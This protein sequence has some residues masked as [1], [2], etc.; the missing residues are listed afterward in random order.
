MKK[1]KAHVHMVK[2]K[3]TSR[4]NPQQ[5][6]FELKQR[7][8]LALNKLADRDTY[9]LGVEDLEKTVEC[10]TP[11]GVA[12]FLSCILDTDSE[13][14]SAVRKECIRL[15]GVLATFHEDL[16][17]SHIGKMV[18]GIVKRLKDSD[19][20]VRDACV[21]AFGV[22][23]SKLSSSRIDTDG[24][25]VV[26]VRPL[27]EALG[28]QNKQVQFGSA[29]SLSRVIDNIYD[30]PPL[31]LQK[32]L[33]KTVK[34]LKNPHFMAKP[35]IIE[36]NR[37]IILAGG[38]PT[39]SSLTAAMTS[40][41]ESL[42]NNDWATRKAACAALGDI[43]TCGAACL[44]SYRTSCIRCLESCRFDKVKPVRDIALQALQLW[45]NLPGANTPEP[46]EAGSSVKEK[47]YKDEYG[48]ITS[49]SI[50]SASGST[51]TDKTPLK[52]GN[53][54]PK[55]RV[56]LSSRNFGSAYT[57]KCQQSE[58]NDWQIEIAVPKRHNI[59]AL[60]NQHG[61][62]EG[63]SVIT[64]LGSS[65]NR[66][67]ER[68]NSDIR[69]VNSIGYASVEVDDKQ[70]CSSASN[71]FTES[72]KPKVVTTHFD[73]FDDASL[74]KSTG[75]SQRFAADEVIIEEQKYLSKVH[76]RVSLDSTLTNSTSQTV[77]ECCSQT[78]KE[79]V[80]IRKHLLE[81]EDKQSS[82]MNMLKVFTTSVMDSVSAVQMKVSN[83]ELVVDKMA[84]EIF[85][86][87]RYSDT[88]TTIL[89][90]STNSA[91]PRFSTCT[92]RPSV[93]SSKQP[94]LPPNKTSG[95]WEK[96]FTRN[97]SKNF[98]KQKAD[99]WTDAHL[100]PNRSSL[101]KATPP[102]FCLE[103]H[104]DQRRHVGVFDQVSATKARTNKLET[105][106][107][108]RAVMRDYFFDGDLNSAYIEALCSRNELLLFEILDRTGPVLDSLSQ[109][110]ASNL[111]STLATYLLEQR[112]VNSIIPWLQQLV[113]LINIHGPTYL[114]LSANGKREFLYAIQETAKS[115]NLNATEK[116][117]FVDIGRT[118]RQIWGNGS[119]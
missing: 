53:E 107:S 96:T 94:P 8:I 4:A 67:C 40:I 30:P 119:C 105:K 88:S 5:T 35:A 45:K 22:L 25:F 55:K 54:L 108:P 62:S 57:D 77:R 23:A 21:E 76:D 37:S 34:L 85:H 103:I 42:K 39:H 19:S 73:A 9:Q 81:I 43:A 69:S 59:L 1:M 12:P 44:G 102:N 79:M 46:S 64:S 20:V 17:R 27:F 63:G 58:S 32:M 95:V 74:V 71:I 14:K 47:S 70:E 33:T 84:Q 82:L 113:E 78:E 50:T 91:S 10:L 101:L 16:V 104:E 7:V 2:G 13:K 66:R 97:S 115:V 75:T 29:L 89:K 117:L 6:A 87:G 41:Q 106:R 99:I 80:L 83:L 28:E 15:L 31:V 24:I 11:D 68:V 118:L 112:F 109:N 98:G 111:L 61:E 26:L 52:F 48:D 60:E 38:T 65:V 90:R 51:Q 100:K 72:S 114:V 18:A 36:L 86:G 116:K 56:P 49:A 110:T 92:P 93:D 3:V